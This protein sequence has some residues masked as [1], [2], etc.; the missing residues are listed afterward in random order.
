VT[1]IE[2]LAVIR[3][4]LCNH[5]ADGL[6]GAPARCC[7]SP[8]RHVIVDCC[9]GEAWVRL[10]SID[11][12]GAQQHRSGACPP[13]WTMTVELG[14]ARCAPKPCGPTAAVCCE[15]N[16]DTAAILLDDRARLMRAI[17]CCPGVPR[18]GVTFGRWQVQ[19]P[20]GGCISST[21]TVT[22]VTDDGDCGCPA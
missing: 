21:L 6:G 5:L 19:G 14:V 22:M 15:S 3:D 7:I 2:Q 1:V 16:E 20:E 18:R 13:A 17:L 4:C 8:G 9:G 12:E 10:V 11:P